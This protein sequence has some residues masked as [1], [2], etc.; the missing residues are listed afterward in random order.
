MLTAM[1]L[2]TGGLLLALF[3]AA[4]DASAQR[5]DEQEPGGVPPGSHDGGGD[6]GSS[7]GGF[8]ESIFGSDEDLLDLEEPLIDVLADHDWNVPPPE[9]GFPPASDLARR[10][11]FGP[12]TLPVELPAYKAYV[13]RVAGRLLDGVGVTGFVPKVEIASTESVWGSVYPDGTILLSLGTL[14]NLENEDQFAA[15]LAHELS[16]VLLKHYGEDWFMEAQDRGLAIYNLVL[17]IRR[18]IEI[19]QG[20]YSES[21][22]W[23]GLKNQLIAE[24][25]VLGNDIF[26]D[27]PFKR[28]QEDEADILGVDLLV[29]ANYNPTGMIGLLKSVLAKEERDKKEAE[30]L[31]KEQR[32]A[33]RG[34][35]HDFSSVFSAIG[36]LFG[37]ALSGLKSELREEFG[38]GHRPTDER[39]E[40]VR[41]YFG[42]HYGKRIHPKVDEQ[43]WEV[44]LALPSVVQVLD[45]YR[46]VTLA[47][48]A[49]NQGK[50]EPAVRRLRQSLETLDSRHVM[51]RLVAAEMSLAA[52]DH[53]LA[54]A[55]FESSQ[56]GYKP[57]IS[58]FR[59][60]ADALAESGDTDG[61]FA[62]LDKGDSELGAPPQ[63]LPM[64]IGLLTAT[65]RVGN[66]EKL[67][68]T[69]AMVRCRVEGLEGLT[70]QC[71]KAADGNYKPVVATLPEAVSGKLATLPR[72]LSGSGLVEVTATSLNA[73]SG[74][75]SGHS[76]VT[77][78]PK[79][80]RLAVVESRAGWSRVRD[81]WGNAAWVSASYTRP[82]GTPSVKKKKT[83]REE[84]QQAAPAKESKP[85]Q[86]TAAKEKSETS[87]QSPEAR[88]K[89]LK[90][91]REQDLITEEEYAEKRQE[92]LDKL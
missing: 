6:S 80:E 29:K 54:A 85:P 56:S 72:G 55:F 35:G 63:L 65:G 21:N 67:E 12:D 83:A 7:G 48:K 89:K 74:P 88:L 77:K 42:K 73:R 25:I 71:E 92:I 49:F 33:A 1:K 32:A 23:S 86:K 40:M 47:R 87:E 58:V 79:G 69:S 15:L 41:K 34:G 39:I 57:P 44:L 5:R 43:S 81:R 13:E 59:G 30:R 70:K 75:G 76:I 37:D 90:S 11:V 45:G 82:I 8:F 78:Y 53:E 46:A 36:D 26:L 68:R 20:Q 60:Y 27:A 2:A 18:E 22:M 50:V 84:S 31:K 61:A 14:R 62:V 52:R 38:K 28:G 17:D 19:K 3:V 10:E 66:K 51:P 9:Q 91:L 4:T 16:H 24:A 64:R